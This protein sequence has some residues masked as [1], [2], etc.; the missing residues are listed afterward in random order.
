MTEQQAKDLKR[1]IEDVCKVNL[2]LNTRE[3]RY[4]NARAIGYEILRNTEY[5][6]FK[7]IARYFNKSHCTVLHCLKNFKYM[8]LSDAQMKRNHQEVKRIWSQISDEYKDLTPIKIKKQL[9]N[10]E[11]QNKM[12]NLSLIDVQK[13]FETRL[14]K[15]ELQLKNAKSS[16]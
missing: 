6:S 16:S 10:L 7:T 1:I 9:K 11:E 2:K 12:L 3:R 5:Q 8:L 13:R 14:K 4:I 15:I